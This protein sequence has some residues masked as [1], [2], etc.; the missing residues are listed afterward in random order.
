MAA[1]HCRT[2]AIIISDDEDDAPIIPKSSKAPQPRAAVLRKRSTTNTLIQP[3]CQATGRYSSQVAPSTLE[4]GNAVVHIQRPERAASAT[5][6]TAVS[7]T[8][9][10]HNQHSV[11]TAL[12]GLQKRNL[13]FSD[14][15]TKTHTVVK[16]RR[17]RSESCLDHVSTEKGSQPG[18]LCPPMELSLCGP[19]RKH[20]PDTLGSSPAMAQPLLPTPKAPC[21]ATDHKNRPQL[22]PP[23]ILQNANR[24]A[25][26]SPK[27]SS[28]LSSRKRKAVDY[29]MNDPKRAKPANDPLSN[30][31][32]VGLWSVPAYNPSKD[33]NDEESKPALAT[34]QDHL[35]TLASIVSDADKSNIVSENKDNAKASPVKPPRK[36]RSTPWTCAQLSDLGAL[37]QRSVPWEE[38]AERSNKTT[39]ECLE[40][41]SI[42]VGMPLMDFADKGLNRAKM[43]KFRERKQTYK[44]MEKEAKKIH[45]R[46]ARQ[47]AK[48][49]K[50]LAKA[51]RAQRKSILEDAAKEAA[52]GAYTN[53][54]RS[55][56]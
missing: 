36:P 9:A 30:P 19:A 16:D 54:P 26:L 39:K 35:P 51:G 53:G 48:A 45:R 15:C 12:R 41:Y 46:E 49:E 10:E 56:A 31:A 37:I 55:F 52:G 28:T 22:V 23:Q 34:L 1:I 32:N 25:P 27:P 2:E 3:R 14:S 13:S 44:D 40:L 4:R 18:T 11:H 29:V 6:Q 38:F 20:P 47:Q 5:G 21:M 7:V 17:S 24:P 8:E 33:N 42:V 43:A 50:E